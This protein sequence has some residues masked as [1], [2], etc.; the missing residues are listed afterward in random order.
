[1]AFRAC[2]LAPSASK[3]L[4]EKALLTFSSIHYVNIQIFKSKLHV[5]EI[6]PQYITSADCAFSDRFL[7]FPGETICVQLVFSIRCIT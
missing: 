7:K 4:V 3:N 2:F 5:N 6:L 1:M